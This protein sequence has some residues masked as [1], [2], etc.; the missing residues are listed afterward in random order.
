MSKFNHINKKYGKIGAA[1]AKKFKKA[2]QRKKKKVPKKAAKSANRT[3]TIKSFNKQV[4]PKSMIL[5]VNTEIQA[6]LPASSLVTPNWT[7]YFDIKLNDVIFPYQPSATGTQTIT[8]AGFTL[9]ANTAPIAT[10]LP[11]GVNSMLRAGNN[12]IYRCFQVHAAQIITSWDCRTTNDNFAAA[13]CAMNPAVAAPNITYE[14]II[15]RPFS[16]GRIVRQAD[17][18][19]SKLSYYVRMRDLLGMSKIQYD[20]LGKEMGIDGNA[21]EV[22]GTYSGSFLATPKIQYVFRNSIMTMDNNTNSAIID[23]RVQL[24]QWVEF[25]HYSPEVSTT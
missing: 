14:G 10:T 3:V 20:V 18:S 1:N 17:S 11:L 8:A 25:F 13:I 2:V 15:Q 5:E 4:F 24:K 9:V 21:R 19:V 6:F 12:G 23:V 7:T 16:K 22:Q